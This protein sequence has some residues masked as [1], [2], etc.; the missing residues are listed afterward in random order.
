M[1]APK[2]QP[3][4]ESSGRKKGVVNKTTADIKEMINN[5]LH[6]AG[7]EDYLVRQAGENPVAFMGLIGKILPKQVD[8]DANVNGNLNISKIVRSIIDPIN[9]TD[10]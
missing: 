2:G 10:S 8:L 9:N 4:P 7:G 3:K 6:L 1:A 5:A